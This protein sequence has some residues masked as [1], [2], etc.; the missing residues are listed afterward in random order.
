MIL[1]SQPFGIGDAIFCQSIAQY[2]ISKGHEVMWPVKE[3]YLNDLQK[4][5]PQIKWVK[6]TDVPAQ[7]LKY[8]WKKTIQHL[9]QEVTVIP[10]RWANE[11][12]RVPYK[13]CMRAKFHL[14]KMDWT[15]WKDHAMWL[16]SETE[17]KV[18]DEPFNLISN[19]FGSDFQHKANIKVKNGLKNIYIKQTPGKSLFDW[20]SLME[21][22]TEIHFVSSS[23]IYLLEM[24][25]LVAKK[26][27]IYKREPVEHSHVNYE[28]I[29]KSHEYKL[30]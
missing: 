23:N 9:G 8:K 3:H 22:A 7:W 12:M 20:A 18:P 15:T 4:A 25:N 5:Y 14:M 26:I 1:I 29:L 17:I 21:Q 30:M 6:E 28:Y 19:V 13:D 11:I 27:C 24:L 2:F 16:R 10:L